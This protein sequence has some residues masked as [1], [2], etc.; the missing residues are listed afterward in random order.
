VENEGKERREMRVR[1][2]ARPSP[3]CTQPKPALPE[4]KLVFVLAF[5]GLGETGLMI[6]ST[7]ITNWKGGG[8]RRDTSADWVV[9]YIPVSSDQ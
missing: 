6:S 3:V 8:R 9:R 5:L 2:K 4:L 1:M 7:Q